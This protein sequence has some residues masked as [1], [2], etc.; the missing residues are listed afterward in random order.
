[1]LSVL[2]LAATSAYAQPQGRGN[3]QACPEG[4]ELN[5]G[6][7]QAAPTVTEIPAECPVSR[8]GG[9]QVVKISEEL[10]VS[11][12]SPSSTA[13]ATACQEAGGILQTEGVGTSM[14]N[15]L[16]RLPPGETVTECEVGILNEELGL[17]EIKPGN[18]GS[19]RA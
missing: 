13:F 1:M 11:E 8:V 18:R 16:F 5:R 9:F 15:C 7:C 3:S 6:V 10:C 2:T 17:C 14:M 19:N 4:F 12:S